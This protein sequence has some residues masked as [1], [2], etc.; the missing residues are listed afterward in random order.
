MLKNR[1][2]SKHIADAG[3]GELV[4]KLKYKAEWE[5]KHLVKI[6]QWFASS[7]TC[8]AC[9]HK[10]E[11]M[12]L[13]IRH[14]ICEKCHTNHDRDVNAAVNIRRQGIVKLIEESLLLKGCCIIVLHYR[15]A[16]EVRNGD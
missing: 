4:R 15:P 8:S 5:G 2:L 11:A 13:N 14:W 12:P 16:L 6:N 3:W 7:K 9:G 10:A 1:R